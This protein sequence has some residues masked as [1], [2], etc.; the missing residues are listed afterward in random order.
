[1]ALSE[2]FDYFRSYD[3]ASFYVVACKG[4]EP[5]EAEIVAFEAEVG[6][7]MTRTRYFESLPNRAKRD[8]F[9]DIVQRIEA[10]SATDR[11]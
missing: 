5:N 3:K 8:F 9:M 1:M 2:I 11:A 6:F 7:P 4:N 10:V